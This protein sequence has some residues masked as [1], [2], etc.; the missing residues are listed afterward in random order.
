MLKI[1]ENNYKKN[2]IF[3]KNQNNPVNHQ[4][5]NIFSLGSLTKKM[6]FHFLSSEYLQCSM[7]MRK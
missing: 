4:K 3:T 5:Q 1:D 2:T 6:I 7:Y